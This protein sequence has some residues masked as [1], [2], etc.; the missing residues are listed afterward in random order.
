MARDPIEI[1]GG[2]SLAR[3]DDGREALDSAQ[4]CKYKLTNMEAPQAL[5]LHALG[6]ATRRAI[7][8]RLREGP[9]A[10]G[11]LAADFPVSRPAISQHL[12]ILK[13]ARLVRDQADGNRRLYRLDPSGFASLRDYLDQFWT[14]ALAA[15]KHRAEISRPPRK[16]RR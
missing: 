11:I 10:V 4:L 12:K 9:L 14:E 7:V 16:G 15:F 1:L 6:D 5:Q 8:A 13:D 3:S 2:P